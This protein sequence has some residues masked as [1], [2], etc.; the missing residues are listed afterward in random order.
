M[1]TEFK[2]DVAPVAVWCDQSGNGHDLH[3]SGIQLWRHG[4]ITE[5]VDDPYEQHRL[6]LVARLKAEGHRW[7][8]EHSPTDLAVINAMN[9]R[10]GFWERRRALELRL[11]EE[12]A[13][14]ISARKAALEAK[15]G[16]RKGIDDTGGFSGCGWDE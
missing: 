10:P 15:F 16:P 9:Q 3:G 1:S 7:M 11:G 5:P 2:A 12:Q 6:D 14:P 13:K 4:P 8:A